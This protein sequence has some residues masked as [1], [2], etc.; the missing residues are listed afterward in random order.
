MFLF[1]LFLIGVFSQDTVVVCPNEICHYNNKCINRTICNYLDRCAYII[2]EAMTCGEDMTCRYT[3]TGINCTSVYESNYGCSLENNTV[4]IEKVNNTIS[5]IYNDCDDLTTPEGNTY[6]SC[7]KNEITLKYEEHYRLTKI[8]NEEPVLV[9]Y[10]DYG[11]CYSYYAGPMCVNLCK[12]FEK[13][14]IEYYNECLTQDCLT[15]EKKYLMVG[16]KSGNNR[17]DPTNLNNS[18]NIGVFVSIIILSCL[19]GICI[20]MCIG[21]WVGRMRNK[22][23]IQQEPTTVHL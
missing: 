7:V 16:I 4:N 3:S 20:G 10:T 19:F 6:K 23:K 11:L 1:L 18:R 21:I 14:T 17:I 22:L 2:N 5:I 15:K 8:Q 9:K 12:G 13:H